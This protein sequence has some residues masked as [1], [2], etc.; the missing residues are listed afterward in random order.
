[1]IVEF[2]MTNSIMMLTILLYCASMQAIGCATYM[3]NN[4]TF[5]SEKKTESAGK[6]EWKAKTK[7]YEKHIFY[8]GKNM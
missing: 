8:H 3:P 4:K 7:G 2:V 6:T 5:M 1:M